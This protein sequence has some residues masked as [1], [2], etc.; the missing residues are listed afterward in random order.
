MGRAD[1]RRRGMDRLTTTDGRNG[2]AE[3]DD[4]IGRA[5][6]DGRTGRTGTVHDERTGGLS[7]LIPLA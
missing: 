4:D 3:D 2:R 1:G 6:D 5:E 7:T